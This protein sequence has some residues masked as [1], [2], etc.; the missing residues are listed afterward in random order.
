VHLGGHSEDTPD[1][2][3]NPHHAL[4]TLGQTSTELGKDFI[5]LI[6]SVNLSSPSALLETHLTIPNS[7]ALMLTLV[8]KFNLP[9]SSKPE[10]VFIVDRSGSMVPRV[11]PLKYSLSVF[12][13]SLPLGINF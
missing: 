5:L 1:H 8:P 9:E 13:K 3:F 2:A 11:A 6:K 12:L 4:A 7:K 10:V